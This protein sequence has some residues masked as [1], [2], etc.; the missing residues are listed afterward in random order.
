MTL[1]P[2]FED[3]DNKTFLVIGGGKVAT[4][5]V[6][7]LKQFTNNIVVI[8]KQTNITNVNVINKE[9]SEDD[10]LLA[11]YVIGATD[12]SAVNEQIYYLCKAKNIPVNIVDNPQLCTFI[13]PSLI[14]KGDL[15]IGITTSGK[16]PATSQYI[17]QEIEKILPNN[18][19][20]V[21]DEMSKFRQNLKSQVPNQN[22]RAKILKEKLAEL[23]NE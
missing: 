18:I 12:D 2:F 13:F 23:I 19:E 5:K 9:F 10:L 6:E 8:A 17:R 3:I 14:K 22:D 7:K 15:T 4:G 21:L 20:F 1:F 11:D 16:S